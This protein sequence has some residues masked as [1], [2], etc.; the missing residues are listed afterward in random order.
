MKSSALTKLALNRR[1]CGQE[2]TACAQNAKHGMHYAQLHIFKD[3]FVNITSFVCSGF[4]SPAMCS[5]KR[6]SSA[7]LRNLLKKTKRV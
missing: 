5:L 7:L 2:T 4:I 1:T 3:F 6:C